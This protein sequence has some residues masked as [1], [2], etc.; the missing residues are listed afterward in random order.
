M[1]LRLTVQGN[2]GVTG[3]MFDAA[4]RRRKQHGGTPCRFPDRVGFALSRLRIA[5][6]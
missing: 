2:D 6:F 4:L 5:G 3:E 1:A